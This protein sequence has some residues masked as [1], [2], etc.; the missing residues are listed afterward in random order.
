MK[1][2]GPFKPGEIIRG[3]IA[4]TV[5]DP[6]VAKLQEPH[7]GKS[8]EML[9]GRIEPQS[10][11][12]LKWHPFAIDPKMD[13]SKEERTLIT[14]KLDERSDGTLVTISEEGFEKIP[15]ARRAEAFK[16]NDGG[17]AH[18]LILLDK[19]LHQTK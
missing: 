19:Y 15:E 6:E 16:A 11:F 1:L 12:E 2:D 14:F 3:T 17:W 7:V 9:V 8:V 10:R 18:Q 5:A 13:Y 4:M